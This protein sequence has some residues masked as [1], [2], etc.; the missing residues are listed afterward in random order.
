MRTEIYGDQIILK[1]Y[2]ESFAPL[3]FEA[4][5][6]SRRDPEFTRWM[7]WCHENYT[8]EESREFVGKT[9]E[10]RRRPEDVWRA[11]MEFGYGIFDAVTG[12]FVGG[13]GLN[14]PNEAHK[15]YNLGY[16][17]RISAQKRGIASRATRALAQAA[18]EDLPINRLEILAAT[19]NISS[20]KTAEKAGARPEGILRKRLIIGGRI[21]DAALFS[22]I[23]EDFQPS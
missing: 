16:W 8:I 14:Q 23:R 5:L 9:V 20:R 6:E 1:A 17:V 2:E 15:F 21:H 18:F 19:E 7:P 13:I 4:A 3:L 12:E 10:N 11:G 22:F